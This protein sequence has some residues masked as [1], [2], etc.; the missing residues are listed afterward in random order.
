MLFCKSNG[1]FVLFSFPNEK[2]C[3]GLL[4][5]FVLLTNVVL[6]FIFVKLGQRLLNVQVLS[7]KDL[8][9]MYCDVLTFILET[10]NRD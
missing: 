5:N 7:G 8:V 4:L 3:D 9:L 10:V 1:I 6:L 2:E